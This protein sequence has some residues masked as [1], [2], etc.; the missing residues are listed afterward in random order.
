MLIYTQTKGT[1]P[2]KGK[3][4]RR[5]AKVK[6][7]NMNMNMNKNNILLL[8]QGKSNEEG[9]EI[10][11]AHGYEPSEAAEDWDAPGCDYISDSYFKRADDENSIISFVQ[12]RNVNDI[13]ENDDKSLDF[14]IK[15]Y[16]QQ[17]ETGDTVSTDNADWL[18]SM[19]NSML[20]AGAY[21]LEDI[22]AIC[23]LEKEYASECASIAEQCEEEG[24]PAHGSNYE[25][26]CEFARRWYDEQIEMIDSKYEES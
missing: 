26:R 9:E 18:L 21:S 23:Q 13:P 4:R 22:E 20:K 1:S 19:K 15:E 12:F 3:E 11:K 5:A 14:V 8:L 24:Y 2:K 7:M 10:L 17:V 16:W 6:N 25:L